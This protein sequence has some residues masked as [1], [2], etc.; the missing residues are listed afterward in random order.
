MI[1]LL[2]LIGQPLQPVQAIQAPQDSALRAP[3]PELTPPAPE[4]GPVLS[5]AEALELARTQSPDLAVALERVVQANDNVL[6]AWATLKPTLTA[7]GTVTHNSYSTFTINNTNTFQYRDAGPNSQSGSLQLAWNLFNLRAL[8][9]IQSAYQ[10]VDVAKLNETQQRRELLL[11][12]ASTYYAGVNLRELARITI[13][14]ATATRAHARDAQARY[15]AGLVQLSA[16]LRARIDFL[17]ADQETRRAQF[18]YAASK[19]QLAALLD[20]RDT[21]FELAPP[22]QPP[23]EIQGELKDLLERAMRDR[24]EMAAAR[25]NEEIAARLKTDAWAQFLPTLALTGTARY[26]N[27]STLFSGDKSTWA[28]ALALTLPIYDGGFRYVALRDANSQIR[29]AHDQTRSQAARIED[30]LRRALLDLA[31]AR[32]L[33]EEAE[34]S[35]RA[36]AENERLVQAQFDAGTSSQVE[37]SDAEAALF[38]SES[39]AIQQRLSVQLAALRVAKAVGAFDVGP[40]GAR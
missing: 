35:R 39:N 27:P 28:V 26:N 5:L 15:E 36:S 21:A 2:F 29:Q 22:A 34:Q 11:S 24:P 7:A 23:A 37:V 13:R 32:A 40:G 10:N 25:A 8:P 1:A 16:A 14:Q 20:R 18:S 17:N 6:R 9:A 4:E 33:R 31:S 38:Q 30:E 3:L 19:S 12:V